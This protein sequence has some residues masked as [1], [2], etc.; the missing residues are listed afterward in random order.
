MAALSQAQGQAP[1]KVA[2]IQIQAAIVSTKEGQKSLEGLKAKFEPKK[3]ELDK[4][5]ADMMA[6]QDQLKKGGA[7]MSDAAKEKIQTDLTNGQ[8]ELT[9]RGEDFDAEVQQDETKVFNELG[10]KLME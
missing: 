3:Q 7:T 1:T 6:L 9:R 4:K 2:V 5:Q 10:A 8:K